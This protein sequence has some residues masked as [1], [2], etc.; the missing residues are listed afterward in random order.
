MIWVSNTS[1]NPPRKQVYLKTQDMRHGQPDIASGEA[2]HTPLHYKQRGQDP[3]R[4]AQRR[5]KM[6]QLNHRDSPSRRLQTS[7]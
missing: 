1:T 2:L 4:P 3:R 5:Q 6:L 7:R